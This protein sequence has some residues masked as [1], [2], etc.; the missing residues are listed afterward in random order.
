M[1]ALGI[2][3]AVDPGRSTG[4]AWWGA[5]G[6]HTTVAPH[7][8][9]VYQAIQKLQ[10]RTIIVEWFVTGS[11]LNSDSRYTIELQ[12]GVEA[13]CVVL[14]IE[15]IKV[16]PKYRQG[17]MDR[18]EAMLIEQWGPRGTTRKGAGIWTD[19]QQDALAHLLVYLER[20]SS[21][22]IHTALPPDNARSQHQS[23]GDEDDR[24][25]QEKVRPKRR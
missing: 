9:A 24:H 15:L 3:L 8:A 18:A 16:T 12:A 1:T 14:G 22:R 10:P 23:Q 21:D 2:T 6:F 19:H 4:L 20:R 17:G 5:T 13:L 25:I 7:K 11:R